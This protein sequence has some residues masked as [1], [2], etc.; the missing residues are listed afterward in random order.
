MKRLVFTVTDLEA[1]RLQRVATA[2]DADPRALLR[3]FLQ[4]GLDT[5]T[6]ASAPTLGRQSAPADESDAP[7]LVTVWRPHR[8]ADSLIPDIAPGV[9][10]YPRSTLD[11]AGY[12][13]PTLAVGTGAKHTR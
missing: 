4:I 12:A 5:F 3:E 6:A 10:A 9:S 13:R 7:A 2:L 8:D 11:T 1:K